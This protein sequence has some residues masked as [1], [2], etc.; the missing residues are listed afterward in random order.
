[1]SISLDLCFKEMIDSEGSDL[2]LISGYPPAI[3][4][5]G[6][7]TPINN[8]INV[9][10]EDLDEILKVA[11]T[12]QEYEDLQ[13]NFSADFA[14]E[15]EVGSI[16]VCRF[17]CNAY[18]QSRG[19][20]VAFRLV[21]WV[22]PTIEELHLPENIAKL[23]TNRNGLVLVTGPAGC[24]KSSTLAAMCRY[25]NDNRAVHMIMIEDPIEY[26]HTNNMAM[27]MQRQVGHHVYSFHRA[28][29]AALREDPDVIV[30][31]ELRDFETISLAITAAETGHLV[32]STMHTTSA[33][34]TI[35]RLIGSFPSQQQWQVRTMLADSLNAVVCQQLLP[36]IDAKGQIP[37]V[38]LMINTDAV[39]NIIRE[40]K[41][42]QLPGVIESS[43]NKGM[44]L[45][46]NELL[47]LVKQG[48]VSG[49]EALSRGHNKKDLA[50]RLESLYAKKNRN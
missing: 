28:L 36:R 49:D 34:H 5:Y 14:Y 22:P 43:V 38:E 9:T 18:M 23:T 6:T 2:L 12:P 3:R 27:V 17:R 1:M 31:G 16:G 8:M 15:C 10:S 32:L 13:N 29:V 35:S 11:M 4:V 33:T 47:N 24:G 19:L 20:S 25:I 7:L 26:I 45:M 41:C 46:D 39:A 40:D 50:S 37:A 21:P 48:Y 44:R 30:V 42:H